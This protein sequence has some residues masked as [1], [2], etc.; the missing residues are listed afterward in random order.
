MLFNVRLQNLNKMKVTIQYPTL[1]KEILN[2]ISERGKIDAAIHNTKQSIKDLKECL[3]W[4]KGHEYEE[5][6]I[7][8]RTHSLN[9]VYE[10]ELLPVKPLAEKYYELWGDK[11][12]RC[13]FECEDLLGI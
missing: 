2:S 1:G 5:A 4:A 12:F 7:N 10:N 6:I 13:L 8:G 3:K 9:H 11:Y